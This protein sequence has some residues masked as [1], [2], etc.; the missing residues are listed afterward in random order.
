MMMNDDK[1]HVGAAYLHQIPSNK[2][3]SQQFLRKK[4][5]ILDV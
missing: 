1:T 2:P 3:C 4:L 5:V